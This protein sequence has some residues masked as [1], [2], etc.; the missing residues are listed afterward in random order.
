MSL[1]N[2]AAQK[3]VDT[4]KQFKDFIELRKKD[5]KKNS[6]LRTIPLDDF[7]QR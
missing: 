6:A 7:N 3:I 5:K 1:L 2:K 4:P